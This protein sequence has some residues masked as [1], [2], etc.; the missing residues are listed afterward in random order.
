MHLFPLDVRSDAAKL[1]RSYLQLALKYHPD[2]VVGADA[3]GECEQREATE[4]FQEI[5]A[6]YEELATRLDAKGAIASVGRVRSSLAAACELGDVEAV[7]RLLAEDP[8]AAS[9]PDDLG[10]TPL[11]FAAA[12]GSVEV[13]ELLLAAQASLESVTLLGWTAL[14]RAALRQRTAVTQWLLDHNPPATVKDNDLMVVA[15]TGN[16]QTFRILLAHTSEPKILHVRDEARKGLLHFALTGLAYL[17][18]SASCH[19]QCVALAIE[20]KCDPR[21]EDER[22]RHLRSEG[23]NEAVPVLAHF[24]HCMG[25][26]WANDGLDESEE[27]LQ[28]V[29]RLCRLRADANLEGPHGTALQLA[30]LQGFTRTHQAL[31]RHAQTLAEAKVP[32]QPQVLVP[33]PQRAGPS[34]PR[35]GRLQKLVMTASCCCR[36]V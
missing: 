35:L 17:K 5:Q 11:M 22:C 16:D 13:C 1:R 21:S 23:F 6:A 7:R 2:K 8:P 19:A 31:M 4:I 34:V 14:T 9:E 15:F 27:H 20:A 26:N 36:S 30:E 29:Q 33:A 12:G 3:Q 24:V 25:E 32:Q 28:M 10:V 18:R